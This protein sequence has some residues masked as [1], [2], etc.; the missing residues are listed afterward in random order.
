M[1][2]PKTWKLSIFAGLFALLVV[3]SGCTGTI[4]GGGVVAM[5]EVETGDGL[6]VPS[7]VNVAV[8][9]TCSDK[10]DEFR[11]N[12][13][14]TDKTN[15]A[16]FTAR[17]PWT[18][19][20]EIFGSGVTCEDA[21]DFVDEEGFSVAGGIINAQGQESGE[22]FMYVAKPGI[23]DE[24]GDSQT[25]AIQA[26]SSDDSLPGGYYAAIGCLDHGKINFQ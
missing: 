26:Y 18:S 8:S 7:D 11:A 24:C 19:I 1:H 20:E 4:H 10:K 9:A 23:L 5:L 14:V 12:I 21:A 3:L 2:N 15:G 13:H 6:G 22:A 16:N 17:L 25:V